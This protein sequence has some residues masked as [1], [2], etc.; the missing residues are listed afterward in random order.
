MKRYLLSALTV[1]FAIAA[2]APTVQAAR[3]SANSLQVRRLEYLNTQV[4]AI[5]DIQAERMER[6]DSRNKAVNGR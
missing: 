6:L 2:T 3:E 5:E 4:K 1:M